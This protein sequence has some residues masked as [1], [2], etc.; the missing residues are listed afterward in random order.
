MNKAGTINDGR[1][2]R[3]KR[4]IEEPKSHSSAFQPAF[5]S[6]ECEELSDEQCKI[7]N[8]K[9][10][11]PENF[12]KMCICAFDSSVRFYRV[13]GYSFLDS[14]CLAVLSESK[15][16]TKNMRCVRRPSLLQRMYDMR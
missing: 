7:E 11:P 13:Y 12:E 2:K 6:C 14:R 15:M 5:S 1:T 3:L 16:D 10:D 9:L 4:L 8:V